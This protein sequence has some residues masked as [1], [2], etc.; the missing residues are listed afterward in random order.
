[1][2]AKLLKIIQITTFYPRLLLEQLIYP[3]YKN[4][5]K[6]PDK[7]YKN[8]VLIVGNGPSLNKT[9]LD[10]I[11]MFSIGMNKINMIFDRTTWR[12]DLIVSV[13][14]LVIKQNKDF[15]NS[16]DMIL[17]LPLKSIFLGVKPRKNI[18]FFK[19]ALNKNTMNLE[20]GLLRTFT[21]TGNALQIADYLK[22]KKVAVIGVDHSFSFSGKKND[23]KKLD[24]NDVNHFDKNYFKGQLWGLP[25]LKASEDIYI[26]FLNL[27]KKKNIEIIDYTLDGKLQIFPKGNIEDLYKKPKI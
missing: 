19:A 13:N 3:F 6:L 5:N 14:G 15:F 7:F 2:K 20:Q 17:F 11:D 24:E 25:D 16:T 23:I 9:D 21:V 10:R 4:K 22:C 1:M 18:Y 8:D 26:K 27:F 12:P